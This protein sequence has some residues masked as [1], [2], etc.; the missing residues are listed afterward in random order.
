MK[1]IRQMNQAE[2]AAYVQNQLSARGIEAILSGGA[3]VGIYSDYRYVSK[4][5][6]LVNVLFADRREI[7]AAMQEMGFIPVGRHFTHPDSDQ[8]I[9]FPPGPLTLGHYKVKKINQ[10]SLKTGVLRLLSPTDCV[11]DRL[12]HYFH[13]GDRQC[14][15][16]AKLV[17]ANHNIDLDEVQKWAVREGYGSVFEK[18]KDD[19]R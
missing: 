9:E 1:P 19:L 14:L 18:I 2:L 17:S 12:A 4:D 11:K 7:E 16:Q 6:D 5:I 15:A 13:W 10:I 3:V 8:V